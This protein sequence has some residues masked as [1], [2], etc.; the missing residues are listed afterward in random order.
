MEKNTAEIPAQP[1]TWTFVKLEPVFE[2]EHRV[3]T[4]TGSNIRRG[5][6]YLFDL[7]SRIFIDESCI[8]KCYHVELGDTKVNIYAPFLN[9][10]RPIDDHDIAIE[11]IPAH[12]RFVHPSKDARP[13]TGLVSPLMRESGANAMRIDVYSSN[14]LEENVAELLGNF[15]SIVRM[16]THQWWVGWSHS[17]SGAVLS[18]SFDINERGERL[19][20]VYGMASAWGHTFVT[21]PLS[22]ELFGSACAALQKRSIVPLSWELFHDACYWHA[23]GDV[24]RI[25]LDL[26]TSCEARVWETIDRI[27]QRESVPSK[28][29]KNSLGIIEGNVIDNVRRATAGTKKYASR[30]ISDLTMDRISLLMVLRGMVAHGKNP[31]VPG[32]KEKKLSG[33][34]MT[35]LILAVG[36]YLS[37]SNEALPLQL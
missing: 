35:P 27:S 4:I 16:Y 20:A 10:R 32:D 18:A 13:V 19:G 24:R 30:T 5:M 28:R 29:I 33:T 15:L 26:A 21:V 31:C 34:D 17:V 14:T 9:E 2:Q 23:K 8:D 1:G 6:C 7:P 25:V 3:V 37:W 11:S 36:D 12:G 22:N